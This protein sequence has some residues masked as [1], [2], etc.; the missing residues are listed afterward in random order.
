VRFRADG[1]VAVS[2]CK[3]YG[4]ELL[5]TLTRMFDQLGGLGRLVKGKTVAV[6]INLTGAP[7]YRL[8]HQP[9]GD[10]HY[11]SPQ[12]IAATVHLMG[13]AGA[14]AS[15]CWRALGPRRTSRR[16]PASGGLGTA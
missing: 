16:I 8:A 14:N 7:S 5:P 9:L 2:K 12:V 6:K 4:A 10:T 11:T 15:G 1:A 13:R 3:D